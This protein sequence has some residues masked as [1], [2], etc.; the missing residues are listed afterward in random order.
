MCLW[1]NLLE[2]GEIAFRFAAQPP[3]ASKE[4]AWHYD[5]VASGAYQDRE[6]NLAYNH[7]REY[8]SGISRYVEPDPL[9]TVIKRPSMPVAALNNL[10]AY[11]ASNPLSFED[12]L[13]LLEL[14]NWLQKWGE[15]FGGGTGAVLGG[16]CAQKLCK[17]NWGAP[18][19]EVD[20]TQVCK[21]LLD[22]NFIGSLAV[23]N[24][25]FFICRD[26]CMNL[27]K[28]CKLLPTPVS[29]VQPIIVMQC[30]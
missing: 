6:T 8:D 23:R 4:N 12:P 16:K 13:G 28:N 18:A 9:G 10:Y 1:G 17:Q 7:F 29:F 2:L 3:N 15:P 11:V 5:G 21:D 27:T 20:A 25:V 22:D 24:R 14:P 26:T 30:Q 19:T